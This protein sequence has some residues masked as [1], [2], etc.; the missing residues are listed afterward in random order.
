MGEHLKKYPSEFSHYWGQAQDDYHDA[1]KDFWKIV[2]S[3]NIDYKL[4]YDSQELHK[5]HQAAGKDNS[6]DY[7]DLK[8]FFEKFMANPVVKDKKKYYRFMPRDILKLQG[9]LK[10]MN[11]SLVYVQ[12]MGEFG[13][14]PDLKVCSPK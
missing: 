7:T 11:N 8:S 14:N 13:F 4:S 1:R 12:V 2:K 9:E 5:Q 3:M 10:Q 6:Q